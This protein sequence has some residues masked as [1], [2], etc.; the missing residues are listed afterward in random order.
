MQLFP[1]FKTNI[2]PESIEEQE[3]TKIKHI[4]QQIEIHYQ[5][6][7]KSIV[8]STMKALEKQLQIEK[9]NKLLSAKKTLDASD[10]ALYEASVENAYE[11][12][13]QQRENEVHKMYQNSDKFIK[14]LFKTND[15]K[16]EKGKKQIELDERRIEKLTPYEIDNNDEVLKNQD[17]EYF[18]DIYRKAQSR[19]RQSVLSKTRTKEG[20]KYK[21]KKIIKKQNSK[22]TKKNQNKMVRIKCNKIKKKST[23]KI[24]R[25][26]LARKSNHKKNK[27]IK[28]K[29]IIC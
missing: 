9:N 24:K 1:I 23:K 2:S 6:Q 18:D 13:Q 17:R 27:T 26:R 3:F 15:R 21:T 22:K 8:E 7:I 20:G 5:K 4:S 16:N 10:Y 14:A 29:K 12:H 19:L 11:R 28:I 25:H